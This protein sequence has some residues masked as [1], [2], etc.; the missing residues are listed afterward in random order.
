VTLKALLFDLDNTL[1]PEMANYEVAF[2]AACG[3]AA[4][5]YAFDLV[6][7]RVA[8]FGFANEL[9]QRSETYE[10]C[11]KLGI[12]S[13]TSLLSDFPGDRPEFAKLR[14]W[15]PRYRNRCW[16]DA[17]RPLVNDVAHQ[18]AEELDAAFR[19]RFRSHCPPYENAVP[20]LEKVTRSYALAVLTNGPGDVQRTKLQA[21]GL[22]RFFPVTIA[23]GDIGFGKPDPRIF[24]TALERLGIRA[25]EAIAI[26]D[27]LEK[28]VVGAHRAGLRCV[29]LNRDHTAHSARAKPDYEVASL[30]ELPRL[31]FDLTSAR[32]A[33]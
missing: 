16:T 13:P 10:Y 28:D 8:V 6:S 7:F 21:S 5:R 1:V 18:L 15:A 4:R 2:A 29:W 11:A 30:G 33:S 19:A 14:E 27:S 12:G 25:N 31:V 24:A 3:E 26:G 32:S 20:T 23:S 17:L 22:E 9:W